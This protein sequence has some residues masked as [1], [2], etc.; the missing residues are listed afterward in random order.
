MK[1]FPQSIYDHVTGKNT[2]FGIDMEEGCGPAYDKAM[3]AM[4]SSDCF[5][6]NDPERYEYFGN[7]MEIKFRWDMTA[8]QFKE[9]MRTFLTEE[10]K[11][12]YCGAVFFGNFKFEFM[13]TPDGTYNNLFLLGQRGY[14]MLEDETP[15]DELPGF[16]DQIYMHPRRTFEAFALD[17]E[18]Q[19][20]ECANE[21][22]DYIPW[23]LTPTEPARWY[24]NGNYDTTIKTTR[25][26]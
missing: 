5:V 16:A 17:I 13:T 26:N 18:R 25:E 1:V 4:E 10:G 15:Y 8:E 21:Y 12:N 22:T 19:I 9:Y 2:W 6:D 20:I 23:M 7:E 3:F 24:P 11:D 14:G